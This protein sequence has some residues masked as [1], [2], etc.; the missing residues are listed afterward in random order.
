MQIQ[1][2]LLAAVL[3]L[4]ASISAQTP[5]TPKTEKPEKPTVDQF[6]QAHQGILAPQADKAK[7]AVT[8]TDSLS[9]SLPAEPAFIGKMPRKNLIDEH[10][11]GRME[12][13]GIPHPGLS[14]DE[15]FVRRAYL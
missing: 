3:C 7:D 14:S 2:I 4:S 10:I 12:K 13:D 15:E 9:K 1:R 5:V 8:L 11:F 6:P